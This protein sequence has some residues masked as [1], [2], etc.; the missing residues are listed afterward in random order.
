ML[1]PADILVTCQ[2]FKVKKFIPVSRQAHLKW[3]SLYL[4]ASSSFKMKKLIHSI[5]IYL[6]MQDA[7]NVH[8]RR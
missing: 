5:L 8:T 7:K 1:T 4:S 6:N 2:T 3:K